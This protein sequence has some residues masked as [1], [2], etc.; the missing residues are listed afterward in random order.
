MSTIS[1][2]PRDVRLIIG[3]IMSLKK[4][5]CTSGLIFALCLIWVTALCVDNAVAERKGPYGYTRCLLIKLGRRK[6]NEIDARLQAHDR[7]QANI[8]AVISVPV[9]VHIIQNSDNDNTVTNSQITSQIAVLNSTYKGRV[10]F[11]LQSIDTTVND[12]W[13]GLSADGQEEFDMK[14]ALYQGDSTSLN[15]YLTQLG[16]NLLGYATFPWDYSTDPQEDGVVIQYSTLPGGDAYPY[17]RGNTLV[18]EA[19]HWLGLLHTF[20]DT[21]VRND[22][23]SGKGDFV[24]DTPSEKI[25]HY[26]CLNTDSCRSS[27]RDPIRNFMDYTPD[28][29]M[30]SF[31]SGQFKRISSMFSAYRS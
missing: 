14:H 23:C 16:D 30:R 1:F 18:H 17:D 6:I 24:T 4:S 12:D 11:T 5:V 19:G 3:N 25:P 21:T 28:A 7:L 10:V 20:Q 8:S 15:I 13:F 9:Y 26:L 22:G 29:C 2:V 31:S 27:G